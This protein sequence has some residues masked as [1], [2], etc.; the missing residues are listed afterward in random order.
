MSR[1]YCK[2]LTKQELEDMGIVEI[3]WNKYLETWVIT[4]EWYKNNSKTK[5]ER[6][7]LVV[8]SVL[9]KHKYTRDKSYPKV[10]FSYKNKPAAFPVSR[11]VYVWFIEDV[12]DGYV[13]DHIDNDPYNNRLNNLQ[14]L[15]IGDNIR[16]R[17]S[18]LD[19]KCFNQYKNTKY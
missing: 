14:L 3:R 11:L 17:F 1:P 8:G 16:K 12:P 6:K 7:Q 2:G 18:D 4:R 15:S 5:K 13:V 10:S 19:C 9:A